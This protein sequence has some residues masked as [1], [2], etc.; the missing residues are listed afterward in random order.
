MFLVSVFKTVPFGSLG[1]SQTGE[2]IWE[3]LL[4]KALSIKL[5][6]KEMSRWV[7]PLPP[8]CEDL[9]LNFETHKKPGVVALSVLAKHREEVGGRNGR[10]LGG[11]WTS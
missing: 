9:S 10:I 1:V 6:A 2:A 7:K 3:L 8:K 5:Q 11:Q 4:V